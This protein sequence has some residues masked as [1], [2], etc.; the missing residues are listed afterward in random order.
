MLFYEQHLSWHYHSKASLFHPSLSDSPFHSPTKS[1]TS[2]K[3]PEI[4]VDLGTLL[5]Q[6][7]QLIQDKK[8]NSSSSQCHI[9]T[10]GFLL[11]ANIAFMKYC[12]K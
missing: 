3:I 12:S 11:E 9:L 2:V 7:L 1:T 5:V 6:V 4:L 8:S 10:P